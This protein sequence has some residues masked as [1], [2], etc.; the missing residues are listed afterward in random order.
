MYTEF[1]GSEGLIQRCRQEPAETGHLR[2]GAP[3][4][5]PDFRIGDRLHAPGCRNL[6]RVRT[7][8]PR[9]QLRV[10][11]EEG[12]LQG[13]RGRHPP[14]H[15]QDGLDDQGDRGRRGPAGHRQDTTR[16][17]RQHQVHRGGGRTPAGCGHPGHL[18]PRPHPLPDVQGRSGL[19]P[20]SGRAGEPARGDSRL[21]QRRH[22]H[23]RK[24][25]SPTATNTAW[26]AS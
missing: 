3:H 10:P 22:R 6:R 20:D 21:R 18:H 4:R 7:R 17:G 2:E 14:G 26:T 1:I 23:R 9:H 24:R 11:G 19:D 13:C 25:P 16:L 8:C 15:P 5:Y 12:G